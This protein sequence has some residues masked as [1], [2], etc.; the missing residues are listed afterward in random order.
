MLK[1]AWESGDQISLVALDASGKVLSNDV[2]SATGSGSS[3]QFSG[4]YS[5]PDN[6]SSVAIY[7]PALTEGDGSDSTP[8]HSE[9]YD[10]NQSFGTLYNLKKNDMTINWGSAKQLQTKNADLSSL[11]N[12][13]VMRGEVSDITSLVSGKASVTVKNCCYVIKMK[14]KVPSTFSNAQYIR[15]EATVPISYY[16]WTNANS[17]FGK[18]YANQ[19]KFIS[20]GLG[21][22]LVKDTQSGSGMSIDEEYITAYL[23][24]YSVESINLTSDQ[25]L[26]VSID[27]S[28]AYTKT[29]TLSSDITLEP[30]KMYRMNI[31][32][33]K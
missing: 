27:N 26:T 7:Y 28:S 29:K 5:N 19:S 12:A 30:G 2:F 20:I 25:T 32:M 8:W 14:I 15:L 31:D 17:N 4:K 22:S 33:T 13:V 24:G 11:K 18:T 23:V 16:G 3:T 21:K 1:A 6:A 10:P 9:F